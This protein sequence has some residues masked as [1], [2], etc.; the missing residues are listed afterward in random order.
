MFSALKE[1]AEFYFLDIESE[2]AL[3][4]SPCGLHLARMQKLNF[5]FIHTDSSPFHFLYQLTEIKQ[6]SLAH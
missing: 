1:K 5:P 3:I 6:E 2:L 4:A